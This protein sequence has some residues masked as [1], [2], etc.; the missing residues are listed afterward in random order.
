MR[1]SPKPARGSG[2]LGS[3][4]GYELKRVQHDLR[5]Y[6]DAELRALDVTTP[7]Y[8]AMSVLAEEPGISNAALARRSF[9]TPQT[10]HQIML[11]LEAA[12]LVER[13][14]HP[15][16]GRVLQAYL[17]EEGE[18]LRKECAIRVDALEGRMISGLSEDERQTLLELLQ[19]CSA[20]L[21]QENDA[22]ES[23]PHRN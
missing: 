20:A 1:P 10:I 8:A 22:N 13:R 14:A 2:G 12:G 15:E 4:V 6:M 21:R 17:T 23:S 11:R 16:H 7:Q 18:N 3:R 5:L 9:V 19:G